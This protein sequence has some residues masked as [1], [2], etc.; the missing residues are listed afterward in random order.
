[1]TDLR[2]GSCRCSGGAYWE[3]GSG[4]AGSVY[5]L[6]RFPNAGLRQYSLAGAKLTFVNAADKRQGN[7]TQRAG[8]SCS[9][10]VTM[11]HAAVHAWAH[12]SCHMTA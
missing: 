4:G 3:G 11:R 2:S 10:H 9:L 6:G 7:F 8:A 5:S 1:M 12:C